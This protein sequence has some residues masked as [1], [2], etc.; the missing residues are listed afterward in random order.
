MRTSC[1]RTLVRL[2]IRVANTSIE[3]ATVA[4]FQKRLIGIQSSKNTGMTK[5]PTDGLTIVT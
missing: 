5:I 2:D 1:V 3:T 4:D